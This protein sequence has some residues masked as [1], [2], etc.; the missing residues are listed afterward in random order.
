VERKLAAILSADVVGFSHMMAIDE[1]RTILALDVCREKIDRLVSEHGGRI[2]GVAGDGVMAEFASPVQAVRCSVEIQRSLASIAD[3]VAGDKRLEFRIGVN[4]GDV[5]VAGDDLLGDGVNV[6]ARLQGIAAASAIYISGSVQEH[7]D[8]KVPFTVTSLGKHDLKNLPKAVPV[9]EVNWD[10]EEV[11]NTSAPFLN[12]I[13]KDVSGPPIIAVLPFENL[14]ADDRWERLAVGISADII[15]DLARYPDLAVIS[16]QTMVSFIG[17]QDAIRSI[18]R[19]LKTDYV[20]EGNLQA[21][22]QQVRISVQLVDAYSGASLWTARYDQSVDN[23]FA[24]Q[25]MVTENVVNALGNGCGKLLGFRR[26]VIRR[27]KPT[28]LQAYDCYLLGNE[29]HDLVTQASNREAIRLLSR[30]VEL[31]PT[32]ARAWTTLGLAYSMAVCNGFADDPAAFMQRFE[33]C[34]NQALALDPGDTAARLCIAGFKA[35]QGNFEAASN[36]HDFVLRGYP[37]DADTLALL[38]GNLA[39]V[40]GDPE[41]GCELARRAI[42]LNSRVPWYY[43]ML[44]RCCFVAGL[45]KESLAALHHAP[46]QAPATL[47]FL[48]MAFAMLDQKFEAA[49]A[50]TSLR[51]SAPGFSADVFIQ[52]YPV[53]NPAALAA[54]RDGATRAGLIVLES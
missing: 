2:F 13:T 48:S 37:N 38:A 29:Q 33:S 47:L 24:M 51:D 8:G 31:D 19:A 45:Y 12:S 28:S 16:R 10:A 20:I 26:D 25:D 35:L 22:G 6:A 54:I 49:R 11:V 7:I 23:L 41:H 30:A 43:G 53:T 36:E 32:L 21:V 42:H 27:K 52:G 9:F 14:S 40:A 39:L 4:L 50:A 1:E 18:G 34:I 17:G 5:V 44:G 3:G 15:A 46:P